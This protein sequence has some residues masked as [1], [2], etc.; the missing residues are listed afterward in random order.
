[1][2]RDT[3]AI[4]YHLCRRG[5]HEQLITHCDN[6]LTK[7]KDPFALFWRAYAIGR[8]GNVSAA[9]GLFE[10]F[11]GKRD[12]QFPSTLALAYFHKCMPN[13][14]RE[15]VDQLQSELSISEDVTVT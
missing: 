6:L 11:Q 2:S 15:F 10:E 1:M 3:K 7:K 4:L 13:V 8:A 5:W 9:I 14:D 12:M